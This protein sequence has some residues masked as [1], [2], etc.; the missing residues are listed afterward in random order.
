[1]FARAPTPLATAFG[2]VSAGDLLALCERW[3]AENRAIADDLLARRVSHS[4]LV[5]GRWQD[6]TMADAERHDRVLASI[7]HLPHLLAAAYMA[8]VSREG[9]ADL[10]LSLA[11][12]GFRDFTRIAAGS[13]EVWRDI[14]LSNRESVL[15]ELAAFERVLGELRK[16]LE[17]PD[18]RALE[19]FLEQ[20]ALARR[21]WDG[22][23]AMT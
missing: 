8:Q 10:R 9:D 4:E 1:M 22:R 23:S 11:G 5:D 13:A 16:T 2:P 21:L 14:F 7:S 15:D 17:D 20:A 6:V 18:P 19:A 3:R 12:T